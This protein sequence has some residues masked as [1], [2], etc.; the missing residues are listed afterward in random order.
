MFA[1]LC[2]MII[3]LNSIVDNYSLCRT[4]IANIGLINFRRNI[5]I[6]K[7]LMDGDYR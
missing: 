2:L 3:L 5:L 7:K 4:C 1:C 6:D